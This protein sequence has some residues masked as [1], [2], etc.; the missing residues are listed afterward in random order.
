[1]WL[2]LD[3]LFADPVAVDPFVAALTDALRPCKVSV[4]ADRCSVG[5]SSP[6][7]LP[8]RS[9]LSSVSPSASRPGR[10]RVFSGPNTGFPARS[11]RGWR[12]SGSPWSTT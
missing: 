9:A 6:N 3:P 8:A 2:D 7:S 1:M 10:G 5:P 11:P 12:G 4:V